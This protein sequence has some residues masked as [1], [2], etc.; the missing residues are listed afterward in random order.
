[1]QKN[2]AREKMERRLS[3]RPGADTKYEFRFNTNEGRVF[4]C[5]VERP[6]DLQLWMSVP[7]ARLELAI[8]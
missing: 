8:S 3:V 2:Q 4:E 5:Y 6:D 7:P 1:V